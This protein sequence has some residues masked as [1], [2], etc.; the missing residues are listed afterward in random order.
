MSAILSTHC[1]IYGDGGLDVL[2]THRKSVVKRAPV[3]RH[4]SRRLPF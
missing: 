4:A 3:G 2:E 1:V